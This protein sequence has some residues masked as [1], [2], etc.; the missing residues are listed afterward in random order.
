M[1]RIRRP[2]A[3]STDTQVSNVMFYSTPKLPSQNSAFTSVKPA[4]PAFSQTTASLCHI[5]PSLTSVRPVKQ[6]QFA[7]SFNT[8]S[9]QRQNNVKTT[10]K[11]RQ[12]SAKSSAKA[13]S[14]CQTSVR[15][16]QTNVK[17]SD[18]RQSNARLAPFTGGMKSAAQISPLINYI[19]R[20]VCN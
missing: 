5:K 3:H 11:Q 12:S 7:T 16:C 4:R 17:T 18:Q 19:T 1:D 14:K 8:A 6:D 20:Q 15:K 9:K 13:T 2:S 10:P